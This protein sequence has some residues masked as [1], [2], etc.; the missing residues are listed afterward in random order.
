MY[1]FLVWI[2]SLGKGNKTCHVLCGFSQHPMIPTKKNNV[3]SKSRKIYT[4]FNFK[5]LSKVYF[6]KIDLTYF[7]LRN[8]VKKVKGSKKPK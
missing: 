4:V 3:F 7:V 6:R 1:L 2:T 5:K 8:N